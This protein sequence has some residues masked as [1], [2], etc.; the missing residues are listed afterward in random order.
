MQDCEINAAKRWL[1]RI[2]PRMERL[3]PVY[4]GDDL[5]CWQPVCQAILD[6]AGSFLLTC[7]PTSHTTLYEWIDGVGINELCRTEGKGRNRGRYR[8]RWMCGLPIKDGKDALNVNWFEAAICSMS[9]KR[10]CHNSLATDTA[11]GRDNVAELAECARAR[12]KVENNTTKALTDGFH[13]EHSFGHGKNTLAS[14]LAMFNLIAFLMQS[15]CDNTCGAWKATR[16]KLG[17]R[18]RLMD[19]MKFLASYVVHQ[20]WDEVME[21]IVTGELPKQPPSAQPT[22]SPTTI[23]ISKERRQDGRHNVN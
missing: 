11:V 6:A 23:D 4:L 3:K 16:S 18:H 5:Y 15:A 17:A 21:S 8:Y 22:S 13:L 7:K 19:H 20:H 10:L 12:W 14:L 2:G 9:G 1:K